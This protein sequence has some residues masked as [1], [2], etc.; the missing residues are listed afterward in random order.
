MIFGKKHCCWFEE[1]NGSEEQ[2]TVAAMVGNTLNEIPAC[3]KD[4]AVVTG[5]MTALF[6]VMLTRDRRSREGFI[7]ML[8]HAL[9]VAKRDF[10]R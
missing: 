2:V 7:K 8:E 1:F 10:R 3:A 4:G 6:R 9:K 5:V